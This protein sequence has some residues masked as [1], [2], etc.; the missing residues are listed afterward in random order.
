MCKKSRTDIDEPNR[1]IPYTDSE[2]P[3]LE[4]PRS[5][6]EDAMCTKSNTDMVDP[7]RVMPK[8]DID[9]P[10]RANLRNDSELPNVM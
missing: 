8:T 2:L 7:S 6:S 4:N 5:E 3:N 9:D 1:I 10:I